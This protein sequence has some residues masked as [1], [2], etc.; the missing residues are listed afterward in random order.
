[1][2]FQLPWKSSGAFNGRPVRKYIDNIYTERKI[3][4]PYN[5]YHFLYNKFQ[6]VEIEDTFP[7]Q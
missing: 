1:M 4:I 2:H 6:E 5:D 3:C 7:F